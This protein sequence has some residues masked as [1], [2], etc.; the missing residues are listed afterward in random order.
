MD[1]TASSHQSSIE[2]V[3]L[4]E[5]VPFQC[6]DLGGLEQGSL[7]GRGCEDAP[8]ELDGHVSVRAVLLKDIF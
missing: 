8:E 4:W 3:V 7:F 1:L 5:N 2:L 6:A